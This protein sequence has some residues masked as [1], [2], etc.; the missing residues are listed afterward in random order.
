[1]INTCWHAAQNVA[2]SV[3]PLCMEI[4][5]TIGCRIAPAPH[6]NIMYHSFE[7]N[8]GLIWFGILGQKPMQVRY[9]LLCCVRANGSA[10]TKWKTSKKSPKKIVLTK[11]TVKLPEM[12]DTLKI[13][14][15][16]CRHHFAWTFFCK[17]KSSFA[18][19]V[20]PRVKCCPSAATWK[21]AWTSIAIATW[22]Q[23]F[24]WI[25]ELAEKTRLPGISWVFRYL[26]CV[27]FCV[28]LLLRGS[29]ICNCACKWIST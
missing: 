26:Y 20:P 4:E 17:L 3:I 14:N 7:A 25:G 12:G 19:W 2:R 6:Q 29:C 15:G 10:Q 9:K 28:N 8:P 18:K 27:F 24:V 13:S 1:M 21:K 23:Y 22:S 16:T 5:A 11:R